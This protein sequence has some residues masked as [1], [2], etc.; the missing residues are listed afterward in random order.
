[1]TAAATMNCCRLWNPVLATINEPWFPVVPCRLHH[2]T[3]HPR[4][5]FV[6][7]PPTRAN[8]RWPVQP[9]LL[10]LVLPSHHRLF[11]LLK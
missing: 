7:L 8:G 6:T 10:L 2:Q 1:M 4:A 5:M 11:H 9:L 3:H